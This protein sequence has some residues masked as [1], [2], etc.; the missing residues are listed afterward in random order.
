[1]NSNEVDVN[2]LVIAYLNLRDKLNIITKEYGETKKRFNKDMEDIQSVLLKLSNELGVKSFPTDSGI[3]YKT[4]KTYTQVGDR[5]KVDKYVLETGD[6]GV[7]TNH[8]AKTHILELMDEGINISS[9]GINYD[10]EQVINIRK[11]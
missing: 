3:A 2:N 11:S 1:M 4:T 6:T 10:S 9:I 5:E 8:L 7:F